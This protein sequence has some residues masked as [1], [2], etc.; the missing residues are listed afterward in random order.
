MSAGWDVVLRV[1]PDDPEEAP[2]LAHRL[3]AELLELDLG[4]VEPAADE[5]IPAGAKG[6]GTIGVLAI[7]LGKV[8]VKPLVGKIR[9]WIARTNRGVEITIDGDTLKLTNATSE[10]QQQLLDVWLAKHAPSP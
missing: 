7:R 8:A 3:R 10:Q 5:D 9:D 4:A 2:T 1:T 6:L